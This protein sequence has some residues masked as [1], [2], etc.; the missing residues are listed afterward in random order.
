MITR[1]TQTLQLS[2][3]VPTLG[4]HLVNYVN[5][6]TCIVRI[7]F[8][9]LIQHPVSK[10]VCG[11]QTLRKLP[12]PSVTHVSYTTTDDITHSACWDGLIRDHCEL[13]DTFKLYVQTTLTQDTTHFDTCDYMCGN[14][15]VTF[16]KHELNLAHLD[17]PH[18]P[19]P[20]L[21]ALLRN[22]AESDFFNG[23]PYYDTLAQRLS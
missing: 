13:P 12:Y 9:Q 22:S 15:C 14:N 1:D 5:S 7:N 4:I 19:G 6:M 11:Y 21:D 16:L 3:G 20:L 23:L 2:Y 18:Y 17:L 10:L 8:H